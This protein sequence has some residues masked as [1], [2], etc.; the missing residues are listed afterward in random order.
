[1]DNIKRT[2]SLN[3][4]SL[5]FP[6]NDEFRNAEMLFQQTTQLPIKIHQA[7]TIINNRDRSVRTRRIN[8]LNNAK[9]VGND[10]TADIDDKLKQMPIN[11]NYHKISM[12]NPVRKNCSK[13]RERSVDKHRNTNLDENLQPI[14]KSR[15]HLIR[16]ANRSDM[17]SSLE[18]LDKL[19]ILK[20]D[21]YVFLSKLNKYEVTN[22]KI[23]DSIRNFIKQV[24]DSNIDISLLTDA[25]KELEI[26]KNA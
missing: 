11:T 13:S 24:E 10:F 12:M 15:D 22:H 20:Q 26:L 7:E 19:K 9:D 17:Q 1:M 6:D 14:K 2:T 8:T 16:N 18:D 23:E 3:Q 21:N 5:Q 25:L 4:N